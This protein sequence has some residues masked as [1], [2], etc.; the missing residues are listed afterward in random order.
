MP[1]LIA[2]YYHIK[3]NGSNELSGDTDLTSKY[4]TFIDWQQ[5]HH[6]RHPHN[7][8]GK[9]LVAKIIIKNQYHLWVTNLKSYAL[10]YMYF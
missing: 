5:S 2:D 3:L 1:Q 6:C 10:S 9:T 4:C 8:L 7:R